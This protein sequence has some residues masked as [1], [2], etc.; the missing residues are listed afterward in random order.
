[1]RINVRDKGPG[2]NAEQARRAFDP[3]YTTKAKGT[4]LGLPIARR[5]VEA[6]G[7][8]V[9]VGEAAGPGAEFDITLPIEGP[10]TAGSGLTSDATR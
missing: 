5:I 3:F 8:R 2:L 1:M 9:A 4:G 10:S 7:G 6:H